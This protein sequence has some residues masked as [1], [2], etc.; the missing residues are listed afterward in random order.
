MYYVGTHSIQAVH[1]QDLLDLHNICI[2]Y[3][4]L[5]YLLF[6]QSGHEGFEPETQSTEDLF[7]FTD[8]LP[9][10][11]CTT[12]WVLVVPTHPFPWTYFK[13]EV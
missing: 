9:L 6:L 12:Q 11:Y 2:Q 1:V 8:T 10:E 5:Y 13:P 7:C 3:V 4:C